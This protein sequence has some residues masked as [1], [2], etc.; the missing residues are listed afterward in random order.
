MYGLCLHSYT[1]SNMP[2]ITNAQEAKRAIKN[3]SS[4]ISSKEKIKTMLL[5]A[6]IADPQLLPGGHRSK[7]VLITRFASLR[8]IDPQIVEQAREAFGIADTATYGLV[9]AVYLHLRATGALAINERILAVALEQLG[10]TEGLRTAYMNEITENY[11]ANKHPSKLTMLFH[12]MEAR[13]RAIL[14]E[15]R[16]LDLFHYIPLLRAYFALPW[17]IG[18]SSRSY[19]RCFLDTGREHDIF[20]PLPAVFHYVRP[21]DADLP[22]PPAGAPAIAAGA[23]EPLPAP[24]AP[25]EEAPAAPPATGAAPTPHVEIDGQTFNIPN[26]L[27]AATARTPAVLDERRTEADERLWDAQFRPASAHGWEEGRSTMIFTRCGTQPFTNAA[28]MFGNSN[29]AGNVF[30]L[31]WQNC[32]ASVISSEFHRSSPGLKM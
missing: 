15:G 21:E 6:E 13:L 31:V 28:A 23:A 2:A 25:T 10:L 16:S 26:T 19:T 30:A 14:V 24:V 18:H 7:P 1:I 32:G 29:R 22:P 20:P 5:P 11:A 8:A 27:P 3:L 12:L 4:K 17:Q 9:T